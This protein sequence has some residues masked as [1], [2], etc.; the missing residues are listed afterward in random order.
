[1]A[2]LKLFLKSQNGYSNSCF[3]DSDFSDDDDLGIDIDFDEHEMPYITSPVFPDMP[4]LK[5]NKNPWRVNAQGVQICDVGVG[6][7]SDFAET[8]EIGVQVLGRNNKDDNMNLNEADDKRVCHKCD[9]Q[10]DGKSE[11]SYNEENGNDKRVIG[12]DVL[13][14]DHELIREVR[15]QNMDQNKN[16]SLPVQPLYN[17]ATDGESSFGSIRDEYSVHDFSETDI[18]YSEDSSDDDFWQPQED[19]RWVGVSPAKFRLL[20]RWYYD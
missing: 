3:S 13:D 8:K 14:K 12:T 18:D 4:K 19:R 2:D 7:D 1:M 9:L 17:D 15:I 5:Q 10:S 6:N 16:I 20:R 11:N